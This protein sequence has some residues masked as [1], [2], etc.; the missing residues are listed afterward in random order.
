LPVFA[1]GNDGSVGNGTIGSPCVAKNSVCVGAV[2]N[3]PT[4]FAAA[5][6][7]DWNAAVYRQGNENALIRE[8]PI[9]AASFGLAVHL[10]PRT[11]FEPVLV[12]PADGCS[13]HKGASLSGKLAVLMRGGCLFTLKAS[14]AHKRTRTPPLRCRTPYHAIL[15]LSQAPT[16]S[17]SLSRT[18]SACDQL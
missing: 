8:L 6:E 12:D 17:P 5:G 11:L 18:C 13:E 16:A 3:L 4:V 2:E 7:R 10:M 1:A 14:P 9:R 15:P